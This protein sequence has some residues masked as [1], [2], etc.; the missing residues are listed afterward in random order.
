MAPDHRSRPTE[1]G[2]AALPQPN[3]NMPSFDQESFFRFPRPSLD[4]P[5][6]SET[7]PYDS[8]IEELE[9]KIPYGNKSQQVTISRSS[10]FFACHELSDAFNLLQS[11]FEYLTLGENVMNEDRLVGIEKTQTWYEIWCKHM[12]KVETGLQDGPFEQMRCTKLHERIVDLAKAVADVRRLRTRLALMN[13]AQAR[14]ADIFQ[15]EDQLRLEYKKH[16]LE[17]Q[18]LRADAVMRKEQWKGERNGK[19]IEK[20]VDVGVKFATDKTPKNNGVGGS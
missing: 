14:N 6:V 18:R 7:A 16:G 11:E 19:V 20:V 3:G 2:K 5:A 9:S 1:A 12:E 8:L 13:L 15:R 17:F 4:Q 10:W